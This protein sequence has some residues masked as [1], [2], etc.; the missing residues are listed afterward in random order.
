MYLFK[1]RLAQYS[2]LLPLFTSPFVYAV[3]E[4]NKVKDDQSLNSMET[5]VVVASRIEQSISDVAGSVSVV[6]ADEMTKQMA[7]RLVACRLVNACGPGLAKYGVKSMFMSFENP[8]KLNDNHYRFHYR[9][10]YHPIEVV[11]A[12]LTLR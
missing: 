6:N 4:K 2:I 1:P 10:V 7:N 12:K 8:I 9:H 5:V 11:S 3:N